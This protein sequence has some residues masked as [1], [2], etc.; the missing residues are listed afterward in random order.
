MQL[1]LL[2]ISA[3][4]AVDSGSYHTSPQ[5]IALTR[6][7]IPRLI[8]RTVQYVFVSKQ[9]A[10]RY[11]NRRCRFLYVSSSISACICGIKQF[12]AD[13][14]ASQVCKLTSI[15]TLTVRTACCIVSPY[16]A[17]FLVI[18][19]TDSTICYRLPSCGESSA[20]LFCLSL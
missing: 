11:S 14:T 16:V 2:C 9:F 15:F 4:P 7:S 8:F 18:L 13:F 1:L 12:R 6:N 3:H 10:W 20:G 5:Y 17:I 19:L